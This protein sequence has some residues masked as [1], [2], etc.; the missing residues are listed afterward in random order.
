MK[1]TFTPEKDRELADTLLNSSVSS[2]IALITKWLEQNQVEPVVVGLSDEQ[3]NGLAVCLKLNNTGGVYSTKTEHGVIKEYL[4]TQTF[5]QHTPQVEVGQ[6][7]KSAKAE[8]TVGYL[9]KTSS[10]GVAS[11]AFIDTEAG[12]LSTWPLKTFL[13]KFERAS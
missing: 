12:E 3:I 1:K 4:K 8:V 11:I 6:V 10:N 13:A 7:W 9:G 5:A 2:H